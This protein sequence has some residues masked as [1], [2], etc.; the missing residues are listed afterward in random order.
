MSEYLK[1]PGGLTWKRLWKGLC[2]LNS[3]E[4]ES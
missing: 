3:F 1:L 2:Y 4:C